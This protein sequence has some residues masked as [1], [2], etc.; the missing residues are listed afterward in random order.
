M[1]KKSDKRHKNPGRPSRG[2][3]GEKTHISANLQPELAEALRKK[4]E[5]TG[6][7]ISE[8]VR[9]AIAESLR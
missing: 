6:I 8:L 3:V 2:I 4:S 7:P 5:T 1:T 9:R